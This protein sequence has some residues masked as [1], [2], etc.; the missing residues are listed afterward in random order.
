[1]SRLIKDYVEISDYASLDSLIEQLS[2]L[3][4]NTGARFNKLI[5]R[6]TALYQRL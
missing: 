1:M 4:R 6:K 2:E 5:T 3:R